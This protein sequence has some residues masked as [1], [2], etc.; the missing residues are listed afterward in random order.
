MRFVLA[1]SLLLLACSDDSQPI[2]PDPTSSTSS[3]SPT[4]SSSTGAGGDG[5]GGDGAGGGNMQALGYENGSRLRARN[6][7]GA[8][9]SRQFAGWRDTTLDTDCSVAIA[10]DA[11]PRCL[12]DTPI[13]YTDG[14]SGYYSNG[15][16]TNSLALS[17]CPSTA[18]FARRYVPDQCPPRYD[19]AAISGE[20]TGPVYTKSGMTCVSTTL[21]SGYVAFMMAGFF[22]PEQFVL[23]TVEVD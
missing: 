19:V 23:M 1:A 11:L 6:Y 20:Y 15:A 14:Q 7:V 4:S 8:D 2:E 21:P 13:T 16:C 17:S 18:T 9:G 12:P 5:Q 3:T 10:S 22:Q